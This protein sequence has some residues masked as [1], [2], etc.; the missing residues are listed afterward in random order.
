MD[1]LRVGDF[2]RGDDRRDVEIALRR[3]RRPDA[4]RLVGEPHVLGLAIGFGMDDDGL[5]AELAAGALDA[6]RDLAA[7]GDQD[8]VEQL[9]R[10]LWSARR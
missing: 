8:L 10:R 3:R 1:R 7:I 4:H 2:G 9:V 5:D 6:Q